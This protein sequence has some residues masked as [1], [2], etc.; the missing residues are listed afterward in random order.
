MQEVDLALAEGR[1][2]AGLAPA[3]LGDEVEGELVRVQVQARSF[4]LNDDRH[5][6]KESVGLSPVQSFDVNLVVGLVDDAT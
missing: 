4:E 5:V 1:T 6:I 2:F 3:P